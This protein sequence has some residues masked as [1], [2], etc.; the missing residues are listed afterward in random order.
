MSNPLI[1]ND[2]FHS[3]EIGK[4]IWHMW[5]STV[6]ASQVREDVQALYRVILIYNNVIRC[7]DCHPHSN[8]YIDKTYDYIT[9]EVLYNM[10]LTDSEVINLFSIW[11]YNYHK[12][13]N[14]HAGKTSPPIDD[15]AEYYLNFEECKSCSMK[16]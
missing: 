8:S 2:H 4:G 13:A 10:N 15:V 5:H 12:E 14:Q 7:A 11:L 3:D 16:K 1:N 9:I 6:Y